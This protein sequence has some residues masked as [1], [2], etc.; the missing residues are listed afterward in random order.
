MCD[1]DMFLKVRKPRHVTFYGKLETPRR[2]SEFFSGLE[3]IMDEKIGHEYDDGLNIYVECH[4]Q[5]L[6]VQDFR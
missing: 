6:V 4:F 5:L 3:R 1:R 2:R